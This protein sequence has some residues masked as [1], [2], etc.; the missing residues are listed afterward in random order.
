MFIIERWWILWAIFTLAVFGVESVEPTRPTVLVVTNHGAEE[1]NVAENR[2]SEVFCLD[3]YKTRY[4]FT[5]EYS[6]AVQHDLSRLVALNVDATLCRSTF[7][8]ET[9]FA[10]ILLFLK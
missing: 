7:L 5:S 8:P 6:T 9:K 1:A 4:K 2:H 3:G 10:E